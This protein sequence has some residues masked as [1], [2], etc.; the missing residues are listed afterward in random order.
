MSQCS[1]PTIKQPREEEGDSSSL[2]IMRQVWQEEL[3]GAAH[4]LST[5]KSREWGAN[6]L[7]WLFSAGPQAQGTVSPT[8]T[9]GLVTSINLI[10]IISERCDQRPTPRWLYLLSRWSH[11]PSQTHS[12]YQSRVHAAGH[13]ISCSFINAKCLKMPKD[14]VPSVASISEEKNSTQQVVFCVLLSTELRQ[15]AFEHICPLHA[16]DPHAFLPACLFLD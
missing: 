5:P 2:S 13:L 15:R 8:L 11:L 1:A 4:T 16:P 6:G 14:S 12:L 3:K 9:L 7:S 10:K